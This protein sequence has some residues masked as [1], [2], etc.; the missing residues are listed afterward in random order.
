MV[1]KLTPQRRSDNMRRIKSKGMK[2]ELLVRKLVYRLGYRYRLHRKDLPGKP[3]LVFGSK[4]KIILV[5]GCFWHGHTLKGCPDRRTP[6]SNTAY[7]VPKIAGNR[8]RDARNRR[9][10]RLAGWRVLEIWECETTN[11]KALQSRVQKFLGKRVVR[12]K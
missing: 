11:A 1:D 9:K 3:D 6:K 8:N 5:H 10:L 7:W 12:E 2:P 4:H